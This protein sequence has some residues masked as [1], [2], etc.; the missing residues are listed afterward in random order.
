M[1]SAQELRAE[2][3]A[4]D[5]RMTTSLW[6][7]DENSRQGAYLG[8]LL[9]TSG[10]DPPLAA[11]TVRPNVQTPPPL[12]VNEPASPELSRRLDALERR[13]DALKEPRTGPHTQ[14]MGSDDMPSWMQA[15]THRPKLYDAR[16]AGRVSACIRISPTTLSRVQSIRSQFRFRTVAG[17]WEYV[18]QIGLSVAERLQPMPR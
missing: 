14:M 5:E 7:S 2:L 4:R 17:T 18:L 3:A 13:L 15:I 6:N 9:D 16:V 1:A 10:A 12:R 8:Q 11:E